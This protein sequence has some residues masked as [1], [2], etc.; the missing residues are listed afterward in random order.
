MRILQYQIEVRLFV[1][2]VEKGKRR[3]EEKDAPCRQQAQKP[4][5][6]S[7]IKNGNWSF[8]VDLASRMGFSLLSLRRCWQGAAGLPSHQGNVPAVYHPIFIKII[9]KV[10]AGIVVSH[11]A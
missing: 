9:A 5:Q 2:V 11:V 1:R 10:G 3:A 4:D 7:L 6:Q 8:Y